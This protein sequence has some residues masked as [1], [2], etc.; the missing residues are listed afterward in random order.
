MIEHLPVLIEK[1]IYY[2]ELLSSVDTVVDS[3]LGLGG[4]SEKILNHFETSRVIGIDQDLHAIDKAK[5]RLSGFKERFIP[6]HGNFRD[7]PTL[8][9]TV[10]D[11]ISAVVFDLGVSNLQLTVAERGFSFQNEGPLDMRMDNS[12]SNE[13]LTAWDVINTYD[14]RELTKIFREYGEDRNASR[15]A[16]GIVK[17]RQTKGRIDTTTELVAVI[18]SILPAPLQRKMGGHPARKVFQALRIYINQ[19][20]SAIDQGLDGSLNCCGPGGMII[21]ISYHSLEDR[22]VKHKFKEWKTN[23]WGSILTKK[24]ILPDDDEISSNYKARSAKLRVFQK[25]D[26]SQQENSRIF[27]D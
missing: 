18:R 26:I 23:G 12:A 2:L 11:R 25:K 24:P 3:T 14:S 19:E 16:S 6:I 10:K 7:L 8:T 27:Y 13:G 5:E 9:Q 20:I 22:I 15:I 1:V 4:Y 17:Y 21:A